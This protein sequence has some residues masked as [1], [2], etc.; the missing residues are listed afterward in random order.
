MNAELADKSGF[1][2]GVSRA[3]NT[4]YSEVNKADGAVYTY[5]P[6]IHNESVIKDLEERGVQAVD[7]LEEACAISGGTI[8]VR[9]HGITKAETDALNNSGLKVADATC[10]FVR[11]IH[12]LVRSYSDD[13][14]FVVIIGDRSHPEVRGIVGWSKPEMTA[15]I[16]NAQEAKALVIPECRGVCVVS[17]TTFNYNNFQELVEII[18]ESGYYRID[19]TADENRFA[20]FNTIC[21][22]TK[23]RQEAA[24]ELSVRA[25]AMVVIGGKSSSNTRKLYEICCENCKNT[26]LVQTRDDLL[27][28]DFSG[29]D[30]VGITAGASTPN[31]IIEEV[32]EYVRHG[33]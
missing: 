12:D 27:H 7:T 8:V 10:P 24:K 1:C 9:S 3:V 11:K 33:Q 5:G 16:E 32:L 14:Y 6:I 4:V 25:D 21:S 26:Y 17:Q 19:V 13:G 15:V 20:V 28:S 29:F 23:E 30:F 31:N 2:F 18:R 22:A